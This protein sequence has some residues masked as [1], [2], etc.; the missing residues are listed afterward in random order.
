MEHRP[1]MKLKP[2]LVRTEHI[3]PQQ[4]GRQHVVGKLHPP[5]VQPQHRRHPVRQRGLP[6]P[7]HGLQKHMPARQHGGE[8]L[9]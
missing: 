3:N 7:G 6:H 1:R 9:P 8:Y 5:V 2:P 4:I